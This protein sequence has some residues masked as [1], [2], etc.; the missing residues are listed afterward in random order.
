MNKKSSLSQL[1]SASFFTKNTLKDI[2]G[3]N[4]DGF[5]ANVARWIEKGNI[6]QLKKGLY[7][8]SEYYS[9]CNDK[10]SYAEFVANVLKKP[11]Y[12]SGEYVLQKYG[13]LS[14]SVFS[15]TNVTR[16]KT[17]VFNN[18]F[19]VF[20]YSTIKKNLF[21]GYDIV[22][23]SGFE[24]KV[25][26]KVKA[27]FDYLYFKLRTVPE[28]NQDVIDSLRLNLDALTTKD[29]VG[30]KCFIKLSGLKKF[31]NLINYLQET[32]K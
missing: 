14:E 3:G 2:V 9:K 30:L 8:T 13:M 4:D 24:I 18:K 22:I 16:K 15:I 26:T 5:N 25:A 27:L 29:Y 10:Q 31:N 21:V 17:R 7:V 20:G 1:D 6:I 23:K 12:L 11:S 19:G 28:I 32:S